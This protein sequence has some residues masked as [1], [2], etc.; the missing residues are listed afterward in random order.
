VGLVKPLVELLQSGKLPVLALGFRRAAD[1]ALRRASSRRAAVSSVRAFCQFALQTRVFA[2]DVTQLT[3]TAAQFELG[4]HMVGENAQGLLLFEAKFA[5]DLV[6]H[7]KRA[8]AWPSGV[9]SGAPA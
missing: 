3:R 1:R 6:N 4:N 8:K 7:A 2:A 9:M 5:R